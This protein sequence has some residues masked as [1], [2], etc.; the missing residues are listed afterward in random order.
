MIIDT[1][2]HLAYSQIYPRNY[3]SG[4][5]TGL[6]EN[7]KIKLE[8]ILPLFLK[9][10]NA[11]FFLKQMD[12]NGIDKSIL[13]IID[14]GIGLG[15]PPL[16]LEEIFKLHYDILKVHSDR[17]IVF[18]GVDPR[19]GEKGLDLFKRGVFDYQFKGLKLYPPMGYM[20]DDERLDPY[21]EICSQYSL[22]VTI[23]TGPSLDSL[24]NQYSNPLD[25]VRIAKKY[26]SVPFILAHA[27]NM[28]TEEL[29]DILK[30][31]QNVY[32]DLAG[33]SSKYNNLTAIEK[34]SRIIF[35]EKVSTKILW[36]ID[37]PL[38]NLFR[39]IKN[40]INIVKQ[41][42]DRSGYSNKES[43]NNILYNNAARLLLDNELHND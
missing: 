37:W 43:L 25:I 12:E 1:H 34:N 32:L 38:F 41:L 22:P 9:D 4:M 6:E 36:G 11:D 40:D 7:D 10:K 19:R 30:D 14:G 31:N 28:I 13:L 35:D 29:L 33:L 26:H 8:R 15:E 39:P 21:Y 24:S 18:A 17:F 27:A 20:I 16:N 23:H 2:S 5:F 42:F 3:L